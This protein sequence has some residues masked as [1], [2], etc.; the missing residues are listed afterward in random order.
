MRR[1]AAWTCSL[2]IWPLPSVLSRKPPNPNPYA[3]PSWDL[4]IAP[5]WVP[6]L[7]EPLPAGLS[8]MGGMEPDCGS[9]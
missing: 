1:T 5:F 7:G 4:V 6:S 8:L 2:N 9:S 3:P